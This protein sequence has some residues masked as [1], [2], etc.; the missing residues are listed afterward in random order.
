MS[1]GETDPSKIC[2]NCLKRF[3]RGDYGM[4]TQRQWD[5]MKYCSGTC[6]QKAQYERRKKKYGKWWRK[7]E[8]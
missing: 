3:T 2:P 6:R 7:N 8:R 4:R 5:N 1:N